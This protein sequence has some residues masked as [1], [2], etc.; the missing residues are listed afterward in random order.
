MHNA[1]CSD[2]PV[3]DRAV[4][5]LRATHRADPVLGCGDD[6]LLLL[7]LLLLVLLQEP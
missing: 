4:L 5:V 2:H 6:L 1:S 7:V 3:T